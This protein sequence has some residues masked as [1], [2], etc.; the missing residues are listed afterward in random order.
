MPVVSNT[1]PILSLAA[2]QQLTLLKRQFGE[3]LIP[4]AV[5]SELKTSSDFRGTKQIRQALRSGWIRK[6]EIQ[7]LH[8]AQALA[9][10]LD[11]GE[12][13][14]I[15]L[16]LQL[17]LREILMDEHDGRTRAKAMGLRPVGVLGVLLRA[18]REGN[19]PSVKSAMLLLRQEVGFFIEDSLFQSILMEAGEK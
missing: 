19:I 5:L 9:L 14:A 2:I 8:L 13:E 4:S 15:T 6:V 11:R 1:S 12:A 16:A 7:N 3:I 18:K 10:E 17:N